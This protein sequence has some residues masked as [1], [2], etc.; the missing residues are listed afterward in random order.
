MSL[1]EHFDRFMMARTNEAVQAWNWTT[2]RTRA[3]LAD[4]LQV[5]A[6][7]CA[8]AHFLQRNNAIGYL[9][10][11]LFVYG[12]YASHQVHEKQDK[13]ESKAAQNSLKNMVVEN[14]K[15]SNKFW[16]PIFMGVSGLGITTD[17][18]SGKNDNFL[19]ST[20]NFLFGAR[21]YVMRA[22]YLP[23]KK[24]I[25]ARAKDYIREA[26]QQPVLQPVPIKASCEAREEM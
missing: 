26:M 11:P 14:I 5:S 8:S 6:N 15:Q 10:V 22:D 25:F 21:G 12:A 7:V 9:V 16:S 3:E 20:A 17:L 19:I 23:P 24:S 2:G 18:A 4:V 13:L 1:Y